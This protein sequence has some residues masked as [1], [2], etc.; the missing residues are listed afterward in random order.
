MNKKNKKLKEL[1]ITDKLTNLYNR[2]KIENLIQAEINR[3]Q[4]FQSNFALVLLD[5]D[6]F[7]E[8]N[9]TY[10]HQVGDIVLIEFSNIL[11]ETLRKTDFIGRFGGEEFM[12][13]CPEINENKI[14]NVIESL[15]L[16]IAN[17][18]FEKVGHKT[19][20]FG[21]TSFKKDDTLETIIKRE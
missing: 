4:R 5:I 18:S 14:F 6:H 16:K 9:D 13:I 12:I 21:I 3:S 10:G 20:S 19:A 15:R 1:V 17:S 2:R 11:K 8:V 7:K